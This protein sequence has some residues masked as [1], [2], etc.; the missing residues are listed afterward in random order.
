MIMKKC[1][2]R[3]E[4]QRMQ[5]LVTNEQHG[6]L[7]DRWSVG[8]INASPENPLGMQLILGFLVE[9]SQMEY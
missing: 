3:E 9:S 1:K 5:I 8:L 6:K 2:I 7:G 4:R